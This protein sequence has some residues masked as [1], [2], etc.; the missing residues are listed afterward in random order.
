MTP[1][2]LPRMIFVEVGSVVM[3]TTGE[4]TTTRMLSVLS[5]TT[6]TSG[7]MA[8]AKIQKS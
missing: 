8:A 2:S 5:Y 1:D 4:T 7:H 6:L 3:L